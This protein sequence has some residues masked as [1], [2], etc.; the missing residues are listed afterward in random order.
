MQIVIESSRNDRGLDVLPV[1]LTEDS[2]YSW[3]V[4]DLAEKGPRAFVTNEW[5]IRTKLMDTL[6]YYPSYLSAKSVLDR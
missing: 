6:W 3:N 4:R 1:E 2:P 5:P